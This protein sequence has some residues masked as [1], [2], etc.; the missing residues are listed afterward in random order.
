MNNL[1]KQNK[2]KLNQK[3]QKQPTLSKSAKRRARKRNMN[4]P[5]GPKVTMYP[6]ASYANTG[7][8][9]VAKLKSTRLTKEGETFLKCA[10]APPDFA[11]SSPTGVPDD[12]RGVSLLKKH[13]FVGSLNCSSASTDYYIILAPTVG[14]VAYWG[15]TVTAGTAIL[16]NTNFSAVY[17]TDASSIFAAASSMADVVTRFRY[18]SNHIELI[19]TMNQM[20]WA[21]S[22]QAWRAPISINERQGA[23]IGYSMTGLQACNATNANQYT[24]PTNLGVYTAAYNTGSTFTFSPVV[25][26]LTAVPTPFVSGTDFGVFNSSFGGID[27]NF[28]SVIIKIS[29]MGTTTTNS[30]IVK[31]WSCVEYQVNPGNSLY[32]YQTLSPCD[33]VAMDLYRAIIQGL[34]VGVSFIDNDSFWQRV[35]QLIKAISGGM[36]VIPGPYGAIAGGV[37]AISSGIESLAF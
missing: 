7:M 18:V 23:A 33:P 5:T 32:E 17:F 22:I 12:F 1:L 13:R 3:Q 26:G 25:E 11:A 29:G 37:N 15:T 24:G 8:R 20:S 2:V 35:L 28:E 19:P 14:G 27:P 6:Q 9:Q 10:F 34:P 31:V 16:P 36:S 21:G 4:T 30:F